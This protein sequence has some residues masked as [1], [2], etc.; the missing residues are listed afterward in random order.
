MTDKI[1][2]WIAM[3]MGFALIFLF[4]LVPFAHSADVTVQW[5]PVAGCTYEFHYGN[6]SG[7]Y[8]TTIPTTETSHTVSLP[9]GAYYIAITAHR[10][11]CEYNECGS[12]HSDEA[13]VLVGDSPVIATIS[14]SP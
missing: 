11:D 5:S 1:T 9:P 4:Y 2:P 14:F 8:T 7:N 6:E 13:S 12:G 3:I 10:V